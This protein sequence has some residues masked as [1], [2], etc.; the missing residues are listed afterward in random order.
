MKSIQQENDRVYTVLGT[1]WNT[2]YPDCIRN[3]HAVNGR[4]YT[5]PGTHWSTLRHCSQLVPGILCACVSDSDAAHL[6]G[7]VGTHWN[8]LYPDCLKIIQD[9]NERV[10]TVPGTY[11]NTRYPDC[12]RNIGEWA[13]LYASGYPLKCIAPLF[14]IGTRNLHSSRWDP[15]P[16]KKAQSPHPNFRLIT[17]LLW[18]N[19]RP[20]QLLLST[21]VVFFP[22][23]MATNSHQTPV[24][25]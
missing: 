1:H 12:V 21:C 23:V 19:G 17:C 3:I 25:R 2:L 14:P 4:G 18:P 6:T 13:W 15:A 10:Y 24:L 20:S 5:V 16:P 22:G 9:M 7:R 8:A 11:W